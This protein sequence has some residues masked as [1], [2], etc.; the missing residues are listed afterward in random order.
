LREKLI[1]D[2]EQSMMLGYACN[3]PDITS[4]KYEFNFHKE[5]AEIINKRFGVVEDE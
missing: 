2:F 5:I 3:H 4:D 1:E